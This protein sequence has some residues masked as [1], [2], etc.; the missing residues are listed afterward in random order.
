MNSGKIPP[1]F[2]PLLARID[3]GLA[4]GRLL[5]AIEGGAGAG[6]STLAAHLQQRYG[7]TGF[8]TDDFF[9]RPEQ[10]TKERLAEPGGNMDRER[11]RAEVLEPLVRGETV[12]YRPFSCRTMSLGEPLTVEPGRLCIVEG[13]YC[14][15]P[16]LAGAYDLSVFLDVDPALQRQRIERRNTPEQAAQFFARW[17][18]MEQRYFEAEDIPNRCTLRIPIGNF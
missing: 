7:G 4:R 9:L 18:P 17:I 10:R 13:A 12:R 1:A 6:K 3:E 16:E 11:F 2:L 8:H 5:L 15:H 14:M